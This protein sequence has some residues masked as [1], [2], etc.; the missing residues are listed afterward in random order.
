VDKK[1]MTQVWEFYAPFA[2]VEGKYEWCRIRSATHGVFNTFI[3][4]PYSK[5]VT[6]YV[7]DDAG[8][9]FMGER[10]PECNTYRALHLDIAE[11]ESGRIVIGMLTAD[12]GPVRETRMH[13]T[14]TGSLPKAV[15]YGGNN[16]PLWNSSRFTCSGVDLILEA[17]A[18]GQIRW[19]DN[20]LEL[21]ENVPAIVTLGSFGRIT[22]LDS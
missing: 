9:Q 12:T 15:E 6:V 13:F 18:S 11:Q 21:L 3:L 19:N 2:H 5:Q 17:A 14:A 8:E 20:R 10:Y 7:I 16:Q 4:F 1:Q 22:P